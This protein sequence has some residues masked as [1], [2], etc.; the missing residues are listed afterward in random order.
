MRW[1]C[2]SPGVSWKAYAIWF[3][4]ESSGG[5]HFHHIQ[6]PPIVS[7]LYGEA[8]PEALLDFKQGKQVKNKETNKI[9]HYDKDIKGMLFIFATRCREDSSLLK[10]ISQCN[11]QSLMYLTKYLLRASYKLD[12]L[13]VYYHDILPEGGWRKDF[14]EEYI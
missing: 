10:C 14:K 2:V 1:E 3:S 12:T 5:H 6:S 8:D 11:P 7:W 4:K 9:G 13:I